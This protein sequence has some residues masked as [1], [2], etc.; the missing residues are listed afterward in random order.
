MKMELNRK[1]ALC[2]G[3]NWSADE[4]LKKFLRKKRA[5]EIRKIRKDVV[6]LCPL[7]RFSLEKEGVK[8]LDIYEI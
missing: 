2:C 3:G 7:C 1:N 5:E 6:A 4:G 8:V